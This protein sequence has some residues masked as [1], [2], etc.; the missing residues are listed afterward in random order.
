MRNKE[1]AIRIGS[2]LRRLREMAG[3]G[4]EPFADE[5]GI[6]RVHLARIEKGTVAVSLETIE[7]ACRVLHLSLPE[8]FELFE[9]PEKMEGKKTL[10]RRKG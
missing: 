4:R 5:I 1:F 2:F 8:F 6:H 7:A 10:L 9:R 3:Y